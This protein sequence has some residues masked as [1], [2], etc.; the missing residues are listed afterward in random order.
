MFVNVI[1][2]KTTIN[3]LE[4]KRENNDSSD[5]EPEGAEEDAKLTSKFKLVVEAQEPEEEE[6]N[7]D[8]SEGE[9]G[10]NTEGRDV[11]NKKLN[12]SVEESEDEGNHCVN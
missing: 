2:I 1:L 12:F 7:S 3:D 11:N 6:V 5:E 9:E 4:T 8:N 10:S